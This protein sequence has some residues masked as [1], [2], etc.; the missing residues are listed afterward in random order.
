M[1]WSLSPFGIYHAARK[2][3][4]S[5]IAGTEGGDR[6]VLL[7]KEKEQKHVDEER[8]KEL[9]NS[10]Q[11]KA[12]ENERLRR[13][14]AVLM[15]QIVTARITRVNRERSERTLVQALSQMKWKLLLQKTLEKQMREELERVDASREEIWRVEAKLKVEMLKNEGLQQQVER[16]VKANADRVSEYKQQI[17]KLKDEMHEFRRNMEMR[18]QVIQREAAKREEVLQREVG[19]L[20]G[21]RPRREVK[22]EEDGDV[23]EMVPA[24]KEDCKEKKMFTFLNLRR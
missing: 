16:D 8:I 24:P 7:S 6:A 23:R 17:K 12:T 20:G 21:K 10:L 13:S 19:E 5:L 4:F 2:L 9:H 3:L 14:L 11:D 1:S 22:E 15:D 18:I